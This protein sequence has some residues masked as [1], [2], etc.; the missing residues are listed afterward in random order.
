MR[1]VSRS[2][3]AHSPDTSAAVSDTDISIVI[4]IEQR[5]H[6]GNIMIPETID[7]AAV[8]R[9]GCLWLGGY[10]ACREAFIQPR[11]IGVVLN[12]ARALEKFYPA[13]GKEV[14]KMES[15]GSACPPDSALILFATHSAS[16]PPVIRMRRVLWVDDTSH[17]IPV[18][19]IVELCQWV[20]AEL[21]HANVLVHC[22]QG[23]SRSALV[24]VAYIMVLR[25]V[26]AF[27]YFCTSSASL[28]T[29]SRSPRRADVACGRPHEGRASVATDSRAQPGLHAAPGCIL[30]IS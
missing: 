27:F 12:V 8:P 29:Y 18:A 17:F 2:V 1:R 25:N 24:V 30:H 28:G 5:K 4:E 11:Q 6:P 21:K 10:Q 19:E 9:S 14:A 22:A 15:A 23:K 3:L 13:W 7:L 16:L 20:H 26:R